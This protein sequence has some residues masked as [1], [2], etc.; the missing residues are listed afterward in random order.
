MG[1]DYKLRASNIGLEVT[2]HLQGDV[3]KSDDTRGRVPS[4]EVA[5]GFVSEE[6]KA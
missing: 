1:E 5:G 4:I 2:I 3:R 6:E